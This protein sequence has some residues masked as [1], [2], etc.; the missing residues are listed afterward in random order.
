MDDY[1][2]KPLLRIYGITETGNSILAIVKNFYPYFYVECPHGFESEQD[3]EML[4]KYLDT[5]LK[6]KYSEFEKHII[7]MDISQKTNIYNYSNLKL[8]FIKITVMAPKMVSTLRDFFEDGKSIGNFSFARLTY[9]S[10]LNFPLRYMIDNGIV[11]MSWITLK[12]GDYKIRNKKISKCQLEVEISY[13]KVVS[14]PPEGKYAKVA[15]IRILSCDIECAAKGGRFPNADTDPVIQ[16][17]NYCNEFGSKEPLVCK[18]FSLKECAPIA[19]VDISSHENEEELLEK[20]NEFLIQFDPDII[21]GYNINNFD[22]PYLLNRAEKLKVESFKKLSKISNTLTK[23]KHNKG[24]SKSFKNRDFVDMNIDGRIILDMYIY[25]MKEHKLRSFTLNNVSYSLLGEQKEDVHHTMIYDLWQTD[26]Y[27]RRRLGIYCMKDAYLPWKLTEKLM[28]IYNFAEMC[29]VTC[30][31][32]NFILTRGQQIKVSSQ[33]HR[34]ALE[35]DYLIPCMK[36]KKV[37]DD[38]EGYEGAYVLEPKKGFYESPIVTLDFA[39]LYPS[40]MMAHN[41]CYSTLLKPGEEKNMDEKD[42]FRTPTKDCFVRAHVRK[43]I[44]PIILEEL[45]T[46]RKK[47]KVKILIKFFSLKINKIHKF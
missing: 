24:K 32:L 44:L 36:I 35:H 17:A 26:E 14:H 42:Y 33:L 18:L 38:E 45:I 4:S 21:T 43:G 29:R 3:I 19:G 28:T 12:A 1:I 5:F 8:N 39:S 11:G 2:K 46:A 34:K 9:E 13:E 25:I 20:F 27:T 41:L 22:L 23:I 37:D 10:K 40:I 7:R 31:P 16:I 6:E 30:T 47:A 15:P